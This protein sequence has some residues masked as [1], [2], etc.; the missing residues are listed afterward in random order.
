MAFSEDVGEIFIEPPESNVL[1]DQDSADE[2][3]GG[4][5]DHLNG[6]QLRAAAEVRLA[7]HTDNGNY[8]DHEEIDYDDEDNVEATQVKKIDSNDLSWTNGDLCESQARSFSVSLPLN[9][10][11]SP[12]DCFEKFIDNDIID[13]LFQETTNYSLQKNQPNVKITKSEIRCFIGI[14]FL[15][16]YN[17]LPGKC[18]YWKSSSDVRNNLV[19][20]AMRRERFKQIMRYIH[21][22]NNLN[23]DVNDKFYKV[24]PFMD[25]LKQKCLQNFEPEACLA[26]DESMIKYYGRHSCKQFIKGKPIRFGYKSWCL[27]TTQGYLVNFDF[28]QGKNPKKKDVYEAAFGKCAAPLVSMIDELP[29]QNLPYKFYFDNL[30]TSLSLLSHL[31]NRGFHATGTIRENRIPKSCPLLSKKELKKQKRGYYIS[32]IEKNHGVI[33]VKWVDNSVVTVASTLHGVNPITTVNRYSS[34]EKKIVQV[35]RPSAIGNYN[36][37]MGFTDLMDENIAQYRISLRSKKWWWCLFTWMLDLAMHNAWI[38]C[39]KAGNQMPQLDFRRHVVQT[40]LERY[41]QPPKGAGRPH[42]SKF[43]V[44]NNRVSDELRYDEK[45]HLLVMIPNKKRR[46]CAGEGCSTSCRT[47][48]NK[49][50][51]GLCI[52]CNYIFHS[53]TY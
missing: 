42:L 1:T 47:M 4:T 28:Y 9:Y 27:N 2:D 46:R 48:C 5:V 51:V 39:K 36:E 38:L 40:Y 32:S 49:C 53:K 22:A 35:S 13:L 6:A 16:G 15:S 29:V 44:S 37:Y 8:S 34:L 31:K 3:E 33:L 10:K 21:C 23:I 25:K 11:P 50:N 12:V 7:D 19:Y 41:K 43:S 17:Q 20:E 52:D 24:R 30:F 26:F 18:F 45:N 14:L